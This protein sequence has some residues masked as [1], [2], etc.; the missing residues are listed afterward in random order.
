M[1]LHVLYEHKQVSPE[2][3][4]SVV[5][6]TVK[7]VKRIHELGVKKIAV[8]SLQ[9]VGCLP[10]TTALSSF[11][12]CNSAYNA[13]AT[14]HNNLLKQG[15]AKLKKQ[16]NDNSS[17][18][19]LNLY[20]SFISVLN[21]PS[22]YNIKNKFKPCCVGVSSNYTCGNVDNKTMAKKYSVCEDPKS[23]FFW[24]S[25]H[26]TQAG[27]HAVYNHLRATNSLQPLLQF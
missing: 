12:Q 9:P 17:I 13:F 4:A 23:S 21:H 10:K 26:P 14:R 7:N 16:K 11:L 25:V 27:W 1:F 22:T 19:I 3:M 15:I 24:D 5:K 8:N 2:F 6:Q 20:E 18:V